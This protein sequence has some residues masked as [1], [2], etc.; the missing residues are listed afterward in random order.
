MNKIRLEEMGNRSRRPKYGETQYRM[1]YKLLK[2]NGS[3]T[4]K[5]LK[6][7]KI[8]NPESTRFDVQEN[9]NVVIDREV[10]KNER[11]KFTTKR[12]KLIKYTIQ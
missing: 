6:K 12:K 2:A 7:N 4:N 9:Y 11:I 8:I 3:M 1:M 5:E 10:I